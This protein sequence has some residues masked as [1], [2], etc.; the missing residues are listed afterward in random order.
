MKKF[1][2]LLSVLF[3]VSCSSGTEEDIAPEKYTLTVNINP[4]GAGVVNPNGGTVNAG[5]QITLTQA[6]NSNFFFKDWTGAASG[7][8][9]S[10]TIIMDTNKTVTANYTQKILIESNG[11][12]KCPNA[13]VGDKETINGK[14]YEVVDANS[15]VK[16]MDDGKDVTCVCTTFITAMGNLMSAQFVKQSVRDEFNQDISNWDV[17]NVTDMSGLFSGLI[18]FNQDLNKWDVSNVE[19][20]E[21]MFSYGGTAG[22]QVTVFNGN[23]SS[24]D[25]SKV[26]NMSDMFGENQNFNQDISN[27]DVSNVTD[28]SGMFSEN[29]FNQDIGNW[30]VSKV[31]DMGRM[32][33][34][35]NFN[36]DIG[37]WDVSKVTDMSN[38]FVNA[39]AFNQDIGN[40]DVS[41]VTDMNRMFLEA[42]A[43]NQNISTWNTAKVFRLEYMFY[44]ATVFNQD[45]T[46]WCVTNFTS[47]PNNFSTSSALIEANKPK[48]GTCP[49]D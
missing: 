36:Q 40:W 8:S 24:W 9:D 15:L 13:K 29:P 47:E 32:F 42:N 43:F 25:V 14:E 34:Y 4:S 33:A 27:W 11:T 38:M 17:S 31:T 2:L 22:L 44:G 6:P 21:R 20:M 28:M 26:T 48:W 49:S 1:L 16:L 41:K 39:K 10:V 7:N 23:I 19:T 18:L 3:V 37:N 35:T 5:D 12:I 30:D 45:L 46:K